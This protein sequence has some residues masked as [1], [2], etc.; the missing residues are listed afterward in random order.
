MTML[1]EMGIPIYSERGP[2]GGFGLVRGYKMAPLVFT[3][4]EAVAVYLGTSLVGEMWGRLYEGAA[5]GALAKLDNVLPDE[6][7]HEVAWARRSL[8]ATGMQRT[9]LAALAPVMEKLRRAIRERRRVQMTYRGRNQAEAS[10]RALDPYAL[11]YRWGWWYVIG[12]CHLRGAVRSFRVDRIT[13]LILSG[14]SFDS[15]IAIIAPGSRGDIQPYIALGQGLRRAGHGVRIVTNA[16]FVALVKSYNLE[17]WPVDID[18]QAALQTRGASAAIEG[19]GLI[20]SFRK[21]S[22]LANVGARMLMQVGLEAARETDMIISGLSGM[23]VGASLAEKLG[24]P[25]VQAYNVPLT[26]KVGSSPR[27][28]RYLPPFEGATIPAPGDDICGS[29][30]YPGGR[31]QTGAPPACALLS[32]GGSHGQRASVNC[33]GNGL[34]ARAVAVRP[35]HAAVQ[36]RVSRRLLPAAGRLHAR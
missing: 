5:Q 33:F 7:R 20:T 12:H 24:L 29:S 3:P 15:T 8:V 32:R 26:P 4:E 14:E 1:D 36:R 11:V 9:A 16:D 35:L 31:C 27:V 6:Q 25:L 21:L 17:I 10:Q 30:L 34:E 18:V 28:R 23:L 13:E 22:E 19:G 2:H